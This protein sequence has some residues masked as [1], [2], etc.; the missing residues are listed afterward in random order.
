[1]FPNSTV[2][3]DNKGALQ[4][5]PA[6]RE[7][8]T[9]TAKQFDLVSILSETWAS[10]NCT[11]KTQHVYGHQDSA[12]CGPLP[13]F[14]T[15]NVRMDIL[16]KEATATLQVPPP[17]PFS[18]LSISHLPCKGYGRVTVHGEMVTS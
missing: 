9:T 11:V 1:V 7:W 4:R 5:C 3:C 10:S 17:L 8:M 12:Y 2:V 14:E 16:A 15:L 6:N 18:A 13:L